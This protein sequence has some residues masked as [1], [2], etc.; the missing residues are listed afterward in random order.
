M[1]SK[2]KMESI[3]RQATSYKDPEDQGKYSFLL[4]IN[5]P[6]SARMPLS[7]QK[8]PSTSK[9]PPRFLLTGWEI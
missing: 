5:M 3:F 1:K 9:K 2:I 4:I 8:R 6:S 7:K